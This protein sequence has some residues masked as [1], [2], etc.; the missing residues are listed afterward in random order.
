MNPWTSGVFPGIDPIAAPI[1]PEFPEKIDGQP[2][3]SLSYPGK[4]DFRNFGEYPGTVVDLL[5]RRA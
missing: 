5:Q 3:Y 1:I 4:K 2:D